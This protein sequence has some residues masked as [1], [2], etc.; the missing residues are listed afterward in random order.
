MN[1]YFQALDI[2]RE[3]AT[4]TGYL[5]RAGIFQASA[6]FTPRFYPTS[7]VVRR[8]EPNVIVDY[9]RDAESGLWEHGTRAASPSC[10]RA[11]AG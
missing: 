1:L 2:S 3:F 7:A 11:P 8:V 4:W 10:C 5:T 6:L 9:V